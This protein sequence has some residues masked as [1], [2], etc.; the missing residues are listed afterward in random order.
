[1]CRMRRKIGVQPTNVIS[2][3]NETNN[4]SLE[5]SSLPE[6]PRAR[7][8]VDTFEHLIDGPVISP[9]KPKDNVW[10]TLGIIIGVSL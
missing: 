1:M 5:N 6:T 9:P 3:E 8:E 10:K 7:K 4:L 2:S